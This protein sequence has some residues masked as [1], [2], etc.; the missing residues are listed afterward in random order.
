M[1]CLIQREVNAW[2]ERKRLVPIVDNG[3]VP[4]LIERVGAVGDQLA[5]KDLRMGVER[6]NDELK[7]LA[8][9]CLELLFRHSSVVDDYRK[10]TGCFG[11]KDRLARNPGL[12]RGSAM[13]PTWATP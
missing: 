2:I 5:Q 10:N 8:D 6:M 3:E 13:L 4:E 7:E 1:A 9:F 11:R 12:D